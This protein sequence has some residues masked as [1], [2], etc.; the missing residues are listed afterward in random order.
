MIGKLSPRY[1]RLYPIVQRV[2]EVA[3]RLELLLELPRVHNAFY[4]SQLHEY[5][6]DL[7]YVIMLD[8]IQLREDSS[9][10]EQPVRI[11]DD[12]PTSAR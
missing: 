9:Y 10:E 11:P 3:Y 12:R 8:P 5:I 2:R 6:P 4:V 7:S 1:I